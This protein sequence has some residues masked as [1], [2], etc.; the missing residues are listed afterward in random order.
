MPGTLQSLVSQA[1]LRFSRL[2]VYDTGK[3]LLERSFE[4]WMI[5]GPSLVL[6]SF[7]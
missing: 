1:S 4:N 5:D 6:A 3:M 2:A 7:I